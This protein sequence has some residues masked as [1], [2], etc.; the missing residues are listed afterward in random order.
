VEE[1]CGAGLATYDNITRARALHAGYL[2]LQKNTLWI[3][4]SFRFY[5][6]TVVARTRFLDILFVHSLSCLYPR[7]SV[8]TVR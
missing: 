6:T 4:N 7:G 5:T 1:F 3:S 8:F 2:R